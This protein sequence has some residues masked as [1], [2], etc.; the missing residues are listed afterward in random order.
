MV[1]WMMGFLA[2]AALLGWVGMEWDRWRWWKATRGRELWEV[3]TGKGKVTRY[4]VADRTADGFVVFDR[5]V[6]VRAGE[7][8][9][10]SRM[11]DRKE[12]RERIT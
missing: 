10:L 11:G 1:L 6:V 2:L 8:L 9:R 12:E 5:P 4:Y 3:V 7:R